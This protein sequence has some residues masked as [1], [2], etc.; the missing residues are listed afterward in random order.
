MKQ[1]FNSTITGIGSYLPKQKVSSV[2]LMREVNVESI[3]IS[4]QFFG[5]ATGIVERRMS[6]SHETFGYQAVEAGRMAIADA[7]LDPLDIDAVYF[8]GIETEF[9]EPSTAHDVARELGAHNAYCCDLSN[10]CIGLISGLDVAD[11][12][13]S[14][15]KANN[16]L[17]CTGERPTMVTLCAMRELKKNLTK[18]SFKHFMGA[19]TVGDAGG[20][21]VVSRSP[22]SSKGIMYSKFVSKTDNTKLC[23]YKKG[24]D[25]LEFAMEMDVL[26]KGI[27]DKHSEM[28]GQTLARMNLTPNDINNVYAHQVGAKSHKKL[29]ELTGKDLRSMPA[30]YDHYG[31]ITSATPAVVMSHNRPSSGDISL[32]LGA[33]SGW[34]INQT[35][36]FH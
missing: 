24:A 27:S 26:S 17:V 33:G 25:S 11:S 23:Y 12:H 29:M 6:A 9:P 10:A 35:I 4:P 21:F 2:D 36:I 22:A 18:N 1:L 31:N 20:A 19:F 13:I 28:L 32:L 7:G 5:R 14:C 34:S 16:I 8:C 3:G 15:G 30:T